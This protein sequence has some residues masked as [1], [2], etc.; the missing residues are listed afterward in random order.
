[1]QIDK[2]L[3]ATGNPNKRREIEPL[4]RPLGIAVVTFDEVG[5]IGEVIEDGDTFQANASKK[6]LYGASKTGLWCLADD[7]GIEVD[8]LDGAPG[9]YSARYAGEDAD[10]E[11]NN[12][13]LLAALEDVPDEKRTARFRCVIALAAPETAGGARVVFTTEGAVEGRIL[14]EERGANGFG[15]DPLFFHPP[16][17]VAFAQLSMEEKSKVSHRGKA[18]AAFAGRLRDMMQDK[19]G[20]A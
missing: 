20:E 1:M 5:D 15:Y 7:S 10:D 6:A 14:R 16:S 11:A 8:A 4:V 19:A 12:R 13:K 18:L 9:V 2:L 3:L 17:G